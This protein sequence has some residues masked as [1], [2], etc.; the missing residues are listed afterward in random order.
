MDVV[1]ERCAG[2]DI[3]KADVKVCVRAPGPGK[4]RRKE[5]RTFSTM[6]RDLLAMRDWLLAEQVTVVGME[7]TG[8]YWKPVFYLLENDIECWLLNARHMKNVPG[9]K[10]DVADSEWI[11]KMVE[12]GLVRPSFV[13][14]PAIRQL[15]DLTRYR[16]EVIRERT[17]EAQRLEKLL[18]DSG[19]KLSA[20]VSDLLGKSARAMLEALIAGER[21]PEVLAEMALASMR[22]KRQILA[23]ALTGQFTDH[24]AFLART[25]LD[26]IDAVR[27]TEARLSEEITRQLDPFRRQ[28]EL[29]ATIPGVSTRSAEMILAEIGADMA[30]FPSA[31]HLASWAGMCPGNYESAGKHTSGKSRP[32]DPWLKNALGLAATAAARSKNTYLASRYKR[33]AIR[34]GKKRALVAVGHTILTSIWHML[35]NNAEYTDLGADY[36]LQRTG[37][38]RQTRRLVSQ[39]NMLGY[40][41]SLQSAEAG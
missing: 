32:G 35:T 6:T 23:Q 17:R 9:R 21:N 2:I 29:L 34:R 4:R 41:V 24:H 16:T 12:H 19:I 26:R 30:R 8:A 40:Q 27:A 3:G 22:S 39:L 5:I 1:H 33:I 11:C 14:P 15:R 25:M 38:T 28:I 36:F 10:T 20:V 18:E 13:P 7:A 31:A 37:R